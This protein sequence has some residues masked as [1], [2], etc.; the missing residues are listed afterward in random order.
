MSRKETKDW[1]ARDVIVH[2]KRYRFPEILIDSAD[3]L[4]LTDTNRVQYLDFTSGG[5][6]SNLGHK[7]PAIV[8]AVTQQI[9]KTGFA[10]HGW[11]V[12]RSRVLLAEELK[13]LLSKIVPNGKVGYCNTGSDATELSMRLAKLHTKRDLVLCYFGCYHGQPSM[14]ALALNTSPHGRTYGVPQVPGIQYIPYP[15]CYR[16]LFDQEYPDCGF[17]C[18]EYVQY[19]IDT[20]VIPADHVA[21]LF[22]ESIQVHGGVVPF[23]E[24]YLQKLTEMCRSYG[25]LI[26]DD[27]VTTGFGRTGEMFGIDLYKGGADIV[28]MAKGIASGL[29]LGAIVS[30]E[31]IMSNHKGGGTFSGNPISCAASLA[32]IRTIKEQ[33]LLKHCKEMG[34]YLRKCLEELTSTHQLI[35]DIR[36]SGLLYGVE[37]VHDDKSP[38][39]K[40]TMKAIQNAVKEGLLM[41]PAGAHQNVLRLCPPLIIERADIDA[42]IEIISKVI[43]H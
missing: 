28:Y 4:Y 16:C 35:G 8:E 36:G 1:I 31:E 12:N 33:G 42:A 13:Q 17:A 5:Q 19:Q 18:L 41:F 20:R 15:Y 22:I 9:E 39:K 40:E 24:G 7:H 23:P 6:T 37:L 10:S 34:T 3:G 38:A 26:I 2:A 25:I 27:E 32:N 30:S 11:V 29:S 43:P 21:A 14:G